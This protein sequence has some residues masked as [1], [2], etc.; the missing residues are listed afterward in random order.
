[1]NAWR[2]DPLAYTHLGAGAAMV[3]PFFS[4]A[5]SHSTELGWGTV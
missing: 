2:A 5:L 3:Q 1:M 4:C